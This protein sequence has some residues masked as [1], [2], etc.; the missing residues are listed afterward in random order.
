ML[1]LHN[2]KLR[3]HTKPKSHLSHTTTTQIKAK[4]THPRILRNVI[5][6]MKNIDKFLHIAAGKDNTLIFKFEQY[7]AFSIIASRS[8][9]CH[10][11]KD[12]AVSDSFGSCQA[13]LKVLSPLSNFIF[14]LLS[15]FAH[16]C[17]N[18]SI[19][20]VETMSVS[21]KTF[22]RH[23]D[24]HGIYPPCACLPCLYKSGVNCSPQ[25]PAVKSCL[26]T[27][28]Q[29]HM[30]CTCVCFVAD[31]LLDDGVMIDAKV[32]IKRFHDVLFASSFTPQY[33]W[34]RKWKI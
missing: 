32:D 8:T 9:L 24:I 15:P 18:L 14:W 7:L 11:H 13:N 25:S 10:T 6:R 34:C 3:S 5:E 12:F 30:R 26:V 23:V 33:V 1:M 19:H 4:V 17:F 29:P 2:K 27:Y 31:S 16:K 28:L 20:R 22:F 21:I